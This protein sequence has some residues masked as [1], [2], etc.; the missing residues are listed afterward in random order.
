MSLRDHIFHQVSH[1][2][3]RIELIKTKYKLSHHVMLMAVTKST[4]IDGILFARDA[5]VSLFGENYIQASVPKLN[6]LFSGHHFDAS[7]F[8]FIG[9][10]QSNKINKAMEYFS[11]IDTIDS[12]KLAE[13]VNTK[14][15][16]QGRI[17]PIFLEV[18]TSMETTKYGFSP[19]K[20]LLFMDKIVCLENIKVKG[21]MT[22][23]PLYSN[24]SGNRQSF[25]KLRSLKEKI[26]KNYGLDSLVLSMGMSHDFEW[27]IEEGSNMIR[28]GRG[29]FGEESIKHG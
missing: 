23:G 8:H 3:E 7:L 5:G 2:L 15:R 27:A 1:I 19:E 17:Y 10:L 25:A 14:A 22:M 18:N 20:I 4:N 29:I 26:E 6:E 11:S 16:H 21:L 12:V 28:I 9:H 13:A 24:E